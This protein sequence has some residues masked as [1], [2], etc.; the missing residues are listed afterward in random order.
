MIRHKYKFFFSVPSLTRGS[1][2]AMV[3]VE[4]V[5]SKFCTGLNVHEEIDPKFPL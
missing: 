2:I 5:I 4:H 1:K 3:R